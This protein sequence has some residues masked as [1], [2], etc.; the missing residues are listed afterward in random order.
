[1]SAITQRR[2]ASHKLRNTAM[3]FLKVKLTH[4]PFY[5]LLFYAQLIS[6]HADKRYVLF[7]NMS[8]L[9][10]VVYKQCAPTPAVH[11]IFR[12]FLLHPCHVLA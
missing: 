3:Q 1:M 11:D 2:M 6:V 7:M 9:S 10:F 4:S 5:Y 12:Q 8:F